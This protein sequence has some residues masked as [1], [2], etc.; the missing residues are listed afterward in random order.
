VKP[1]DQTRLGFPEGNCFAACLASL[2]E[3]PLDQV[4]SV[5]GMD[6]EVPAWWPL[7]LDRWLSRYGL[8]GLYFVVQP[9]HIDIAA[10]H[11]IY[12]NNSNDLVWP[13]GPCIALGRSPR[14]YPHAVVACDQVLLHDP[15][16][17]RLGLVSIDGYIVLIPFNPAI[18]SQ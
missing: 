7:H 13:R 9:S 10:L 16:P 4:P 5:M 17:S 2:M 1:V 8:Y 12:T 14:G 15:H 3:I 11:G 18:R 6:P